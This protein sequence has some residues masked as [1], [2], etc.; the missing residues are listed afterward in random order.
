MTVLAWDP[1]RFDVGVPKLNAEHQAI[2]GLMNAIH[3]RATAG[4]AKPELEG[5]FQ[6][7]ASVTVGHFADEEAYMESVAFPDLKSH[8]V[9]HQRLLADFTAHKA[10]F[11]AGNGQVD[12]AFFDCN[13][14]VSLGFFVATLVDAWLLSRGGA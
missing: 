6:K 10:K 12:K 13:A 1:I 11:D 9:I 14:L 8:K 4:A 5:L 2:V 3:D 7:L